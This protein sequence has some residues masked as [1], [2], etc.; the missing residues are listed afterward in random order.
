MTGGEQRRGVDLNCPTKQAGSI[1]KEVGWRRCK[2][3]CSRALRWGIRTPDKS[4]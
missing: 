1:R 4:N 3:I 2:S